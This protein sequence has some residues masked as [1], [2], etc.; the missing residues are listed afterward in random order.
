MDKLIILAIFSQFSSQRHR[1]GVS[2]NRSLGNEISLNAEDTRAS[3]PKSRMLLEGHARER[4]WT[5]TS[6]PAVACTR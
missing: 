5:G 2:E 1:D 4:R 6:I 3:L